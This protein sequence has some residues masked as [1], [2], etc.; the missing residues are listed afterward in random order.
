[1]KNAEETEKDFK[2]DERKRTLLKIAFCWN[3]SVAFNSQ[4]EQGNWEP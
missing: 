3:S 4:T 1:M 2:K